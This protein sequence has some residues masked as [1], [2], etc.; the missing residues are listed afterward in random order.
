MNRDDAIEV[1]VRQDLAQL[2]PEARES[3]LEDWWAL[4]AG[5]P[6]YDGLPERL[7]A[8][9]ERS[10]YPGNPSDPL[11]DPLLHVALRRDYVGALNAYLERRL[12]RLGQ[13]ATVEGAVEE[14]EPRPCCRYRSLPERAGYDVCPVC[15][16]EDDGLRD[17]SKVSSCNHAS[18]TEARR[19]FETIGAMSEDMR[20]HVLADG[21][22]RFAREEME[23]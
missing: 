22:E 18:L 1:L 9:M 4:E 3:L 12:E 23:S 6:G 7:R 10:E 20:R 14:L 2:D 13:P 19:T 8:A 21:P 17:P 11:Y 16:W 15:F 5:E